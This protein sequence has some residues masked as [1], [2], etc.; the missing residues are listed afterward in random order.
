LQALI[1]L[2]KGILF[3]KIPEYIEKKK[4]EIS[5]LEEETKISN[6]KKEISEIEAA[7][8][9]DLRDVDLEN[10]K[11][12]VAELREYSKLKAELGKFRLSIEDD[13]PKFVQLVHGIKQRGYD[14]DK[15]V[16][17]YSDQEIKQLTRDLL[18]NQVNKLKDTK[19]GLQNE[20][21]F[22]NSQV[23]LHSQRLYA[24]DELK[25]IRVGLRELKIIINTIKELAA[26]NNISISAAVNKFFQFLEQQYDIKL[27]QKVLDEEKQ[28][29]QKY[30]NTTKDDSPNRTFP[31]PYSNNESSSVVPKH[32]ALVDRQQQPQQQKSSSFTSYREIITTDPN[33]AKERNNQINNDVDEWYG[34]DEDHNR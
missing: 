12:T 1:K 2:P 30:N 33:T 10:E 4:N 7:V 13:I 11:T 27:R 29:L 23:D 5:K 14:V 18:I 32:S 6:E 34:S 20:C 17:E 8:A 31:L 19:M 22:L 24:Y 25:S 9:K 3:A 16:S 26:E 15:V 28:Q 21:Y